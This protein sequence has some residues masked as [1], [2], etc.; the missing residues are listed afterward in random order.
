MA[1]AYV[2]GPC[3]PSYYLVQGDLGIW[4]A[5]RVFDAI[6]DHEGMETYYLC[7]ALKYGIRAGRKTDDPTDDLAKLRD[8]VARAI[9]HREARRSL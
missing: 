5:D 3:V 8:C 2:S 4:P 6:D 9:E 7:A 1:E